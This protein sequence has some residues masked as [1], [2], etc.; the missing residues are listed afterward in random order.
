[1]SF[2]FAY[3]GNRLAITARRHY[4]SD[5]NDELHV[6]DW[7]GKQWIETSTIIPGLNKSWNGGYAMAMTSGSRVAV[8]QIY[9]PSTSTNQWQQPEPKTDPLYNNGTGRITFYDFT[10]TQTFSGNN[11]FFSMY[12]IKSEFFFKY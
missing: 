4:Q 9:W 3:T 6:L 1:M 12:K 10:L 11:I 8:S 7:S 5:N 2:I